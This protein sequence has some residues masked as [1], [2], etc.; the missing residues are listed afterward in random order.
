M[1]ELQPLPVN[2][3]FE[4]DFVTQLVVI[5]T[6]DDMNQ[7]AEKVA[8]HVVGKRLPKR[9]AGMNVNYEG[10]KLPN[11]MTVADAGIGPFQNIFVTWDKGATS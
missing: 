4:G 9:D 11:E 3:H 5:M 6:N 10:R 1:A 2:A 7:V 8:H